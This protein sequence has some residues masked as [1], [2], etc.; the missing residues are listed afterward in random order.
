[1]VIGANWIGVGMRNAEEHRTVCASVA[2]MT[3][4]SSARLPLFVQAIAWPISRMA[5]YGTHDLIT[6]A[7]SLPTLS[8][9]AP[10]Y[11]VV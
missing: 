7:P 9:T 4:S 8:S 5:P 2:G 3:V 1:M 6:E 10:D 11:G